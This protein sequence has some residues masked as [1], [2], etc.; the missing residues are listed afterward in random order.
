MKHS[1][2]FRPGKDH[3]SYK[4]GHNSSAGTSKEYRCWQKIK[5]RCKMDKTDRNWSMYSGKG[6]KVCDTWINDFLQFLSDMGPAPSPKHS[7]DR[8]DSNRGYEPSNCRW[9]TA[10][11]QARNMNTN[12]YLSFNNETM[13]VTDWCE[14]LGMK[15]TTLT[16]RLDVYGWTLEDALTRPV[17]RRNKH[18]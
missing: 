9:A 11:E 15:F 8:I 14:K 10:K 3:Q 6:I 17:K 2:S 5:S 4:H 1:G 13:L 18:N 12:R 16:S 7:I